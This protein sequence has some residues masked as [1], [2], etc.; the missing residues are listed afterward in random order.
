L[1]TVIVEGRLIFDDVEGLE[2]NSHNVLVLNGGYIQIGS[3]EKPLLKNIKI[4]MHG[5]K[6]FDK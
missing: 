2:F 3:P 6:E 4:I 5:N 1:N